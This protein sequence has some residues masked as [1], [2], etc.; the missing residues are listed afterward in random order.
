MS[1]LGHALQPLH[2]ITDH[3]F[4]FDD[5]LFSSATG[6]R[7]GVSPVRWS[8]P[9][10]V[11]PRHPSARDLLRTSQRPFWELKSPT[12]RPNLAAFPGIFLPKEAPKSQNTYLDLHG[13]AHQQRYQAFSLRSSRNMPRAPAGDADRMSVAFQLLGHI[14]RGYIRAHHQKNT[15]HY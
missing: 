15:G 6:N 3:W 8:L 4:N 1:L 12:L 2:T 14:T 9:N 10:S 13:W 7:G 11:G 5:E